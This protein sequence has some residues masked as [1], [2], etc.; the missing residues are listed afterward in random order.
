MLERDLDD[1]YAGLPR[2][3]ASVDRLSRLAQPACGAH[4]TSTEIFPAPVCVPG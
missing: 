4:R 2:W 1:A 3:A